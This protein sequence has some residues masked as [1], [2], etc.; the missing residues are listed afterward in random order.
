[1][2]T[3]L[4]KIFSPLIETLAPLHCEVCG[5]AIAETQ[6][7]FKYICNRCADRLPL[8]PESSELKN[9]LYD[10]FSKDDVVI[11]DVFS[12]FSIKR[13]FDYMQIIHSLKY[14]GIKQIGYEFGI[15]LGRKVKKYSVLSYDAIIPVPIHHARRRERG[16]N[17]SLVIAK[18]V[19]EVLCSPI[20]NGLIR[21]RLY[22]QTQTKLNSE[23]RR[24]NVSSVFAINHK[25][26]EK[27]K[28]H[29]FLLIDDVIT[30]GSTLNSCANVLL[31]SGARRIDVATLASA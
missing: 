27:I 22:T 28:N 11:S 4:K 6:H 9:R 20:D 10:V 24:V 13:N 16:Y 31:E 21:R 29:N 3:I 1:M 5:E 15:E 19:S 23:E 30:T 18:G 26:I 12:L 8:A 7:R 14:Y 25:K 17:Q 2:K